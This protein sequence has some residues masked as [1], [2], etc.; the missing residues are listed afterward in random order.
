LEILIIKLIDASNEMGIDFTDKDSHDDF[1]PREI[2]IP[3]NQPILFKIRA[4]DVLHSVFAPH[5]RLKMDAVPGMSTKFWFI[6]TKTTEE[7]KAETN[8]P[9]F[10]YEVACTEV[11]GKG[12]F[13]MRYIIVV[14]TEEE[15]NKWL[16]EQEPLTKTNPEFLV[17]AGVVVAP[18]VE[19]AVEE[20]TT[21][22]NDSRKNKR[23][24]SSV[25]K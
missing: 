6:P 16:K 11:C 19:T 9:N 5:F 25:I 12:H 14:E 24:S 18:V 20:T 7:M 21:L 15:Y 10:K 1:M 8:N 22:F 2:H 4:R 23:R 3:V 13:A 17:K